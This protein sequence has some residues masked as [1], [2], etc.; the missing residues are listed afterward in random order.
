MLHFE[1]IHNIVLAP[2]LI[3]FSP[4]FVAVY[5][6]A[7]C[8]VFSLNTTEVTID[9]LNA[10]LLASNS[11]ICKTFLLSVVIAQWRLAN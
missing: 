5:Q 11:F 8:A 2:F 4:E 3:I 7:C 6:L 9:L 1:V 10:K